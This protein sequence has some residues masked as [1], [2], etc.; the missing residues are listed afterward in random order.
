MVIPAG[1]TL[2]SDGENLARVRCANRLSP[3]AVKPVAETEPSKEDLNEPS[4]VPPLIAEWA[5]GAELPG[6]PGTPANAAP[7][8]T[9][10]GPSTSNTPPQPIL[11]PILIPGVPPF[12][13]L[14]PGPPPVVTPEPS[15][16]GLLLAGTLLISLLAAMS[17]RRNGSVWLSSN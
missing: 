1:E 16:F 8:I 10:P 13:P 2:I 7:P 17:L 9:P 3:I 15:S 14:T 4:F 6:I 5:P 12:V 11:P